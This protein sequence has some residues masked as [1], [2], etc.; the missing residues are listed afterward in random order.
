MCIRDS[1]YV[2]QF[3]NSDDEPR[4]DRVITIPIDDNTKYS[5]REYRDRLYAEISKK[6]KEQR[7]AMLA[8]VGN[9]EEEEKVMYDYYS[10]QTT[11]A[12][13]KSPKNSTTTNT[14][15]NAGNRYSQPQGHTGAGTRQTAGTTSTNSNYYYSGTKASGQPQRK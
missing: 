7:R 10:K 9:P 14:G 4:C 3:H 2:A 13:Y 12:N 1:P 8:G 5:I 15:S 11:A 6:K